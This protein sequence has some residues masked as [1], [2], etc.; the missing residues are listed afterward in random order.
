M[1]ASVRILAGCGQDYI[2]IRETHREIHRVRYYKV[3]T[4]TEVQ[5]YRSK[6]LTHGITIANF[7]IH[8][9]FDCRSKWFLYVCINLFKSALI[10]WLVD[11]A[12]SDNNCYYMYLPCF[13]I[14]FTLP[15]MADILLHNRSVYRYLYK[16]IMYYVLS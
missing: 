4:H 2:P 13:V 3:A 8:R 14:F 11:T 6:S 7:A 15:K 1:S 16:I 10:E 9:L 5:Y 12:C